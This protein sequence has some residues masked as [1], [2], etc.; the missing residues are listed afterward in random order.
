MY[1]EPRKHGETV[2]VNSHLKRKGDFFWH[3][4]LTKKRI[5]HFTRIKY[6][7]LK[8]LK[9]SSKFNIIRSPKYKLHQSQKCYQTQFYLKEVLSHFLWKDF[10]LISSPPKILSID[11]N[12]LWKH[13]KDMKIY[14][15]IL[16]KCF[17]F[18]WQNWW[19]KR[20]VLTNINSDLFSF[21]YALSISLVL[22]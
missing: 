13:W 19:G 2:I 1:E 15:S 11:K 7:S 6:Q 3:S 18:S 12:I 22:Q 10:K 5:I 16:W 9:T 8:C 21:T 4:S 17:D 20:W 14:E